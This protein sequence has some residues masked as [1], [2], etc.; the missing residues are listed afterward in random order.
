LD[1]SFPTHHA[2]K[3]CD[4][5]VEGLQ[6]RRHGDVLGDTILGTIGREGDVG[7]PMKHDSDWDVVDTTKVCWV[8]LQDPAEPDILMFVAR[9]IYN[10]W[11]TAGGGPAEET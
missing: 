7:V 11:E 8:G 2:Y 4:D 1:P 9:V 5:E 6:I 10:N 3:N